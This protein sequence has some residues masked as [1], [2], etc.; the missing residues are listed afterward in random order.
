MAVY[1]TNG[2]QLNAVYS[3]NGIPL[4][5]AFNTNGAQIFSSEEQEDVDYSSYS[6]SEF[7]TVPCMQGF[8]V[9]NGLI[10]NTS[11]DGKCKVIDVAT[12][13]LLQ[14]VNIT[15]G[16]GNSASF[17][18]FLNDGD[19]YP[20][21]YV[22]KDQ[23]NPC[24][25]YVYHIT[26]VGDSFTFDLVRTLRWQLSQVGYYANAALDTE[27]N[28]LYL[29]GYSEDNWRTD[30]GGSNVMV[31]TAWD[32]SRL[33]ENSDGSFTPAYLTRIATNYFIYAHFGQTFHDGLIWS[34]T[35]GVGYADP[36]VFGVDPATGNIVDT[37]HLPTNG[38]AE[39]I[40]FL[41][42]LN[43]VVGYISKSFYKLTFSAL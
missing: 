22:S 17:G 41:D 26:R 13:T 5:A 18:E 4:N 10:F 11:G 2:S 42:D 1:N 28:V 40:C 34:G 35:P 29:F 37:I 38:E 30:N 19:E 24:D 3:T 27:S 43:A 23:G 20:L 31:V 32:L 7:S 36:K 15:T 6:V 21:L 33:T 12:N 9:Y 14:T 16:H 25:V 39:G 8:A